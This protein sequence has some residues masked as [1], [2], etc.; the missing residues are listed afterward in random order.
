MSATVVTADCVYCSSDISILSSSISLFHKHICLR[1]SL[2]Q[3]STLSYPIINLC[4]CITSN[5]QGRGINVNVHEIYLITSGQLWGQIFPIATTR[6]PIILNTGGYKESNGATSLL[7]IMKKYN[8][9]KWNKVYHLT[10][11]RY[12]VICTVWLLLI[13]YW[14]IK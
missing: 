1:N 3:Q 6:F 11:A 12:F 8:N 14:R 4:M 7:L 10:H 9:R 13:Y 5:Q 2:V